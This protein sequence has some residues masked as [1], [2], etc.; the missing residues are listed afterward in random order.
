MIHSLKSY[1]II[2]GIRGQEGV[3][4]DKYAEI[5]MRLSTLLHHCP[6]IREMDLNPLIGKAE[7]IF[8]VDARIRIE[9]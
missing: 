6:E 1:Q 2:K 7:S 4:E 5:I 3:D 8:A 9:K